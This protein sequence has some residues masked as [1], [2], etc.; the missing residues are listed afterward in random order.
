MNKSRLE[1]FSD[2]VFAIII[3]IM[4]LELK[5][6]ETTGWHTLM[7]LAPV[8]YGYLLSFI[9]VAIYWANHHHLMHTIHKVKASIIWANMF[10]LFSLSLVPF[11]TGWMGVNRFEKGTV[12][13][14]GTLLAICGVSYTILSKVISHSYKQETELTKAIAKSDFKGITSLVLYISSVPIALYVSPYISL[15][16]YAIVSVLWFIP[17]NA[18]EKALENE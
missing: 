2:G 12:A 18:I 1:A 13:V 17:S 7:H 14:Y 5:V 11:A 15:V 4:V 10:L 3:T 16:L 6:P 8:F 9:F